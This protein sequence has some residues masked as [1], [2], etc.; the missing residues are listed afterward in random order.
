MINKFQIRKFDY[1][2]PEKGIYVAKHVEGSLVAK[3]KID[4]NSASI[5]DL[6]M[7]EGISDENAK[8]IEKTIL[9]L[10][11][12]L[13]KLGWYAKTESIQ[14][15]NNDLKTPEN[16]PL[17]YLTNHDCFLDLP[18]NSCIR[19]DIDLV[20]EINA[21]DEDL[22]LLYSLALIYG[23]DCISG[24]DIKH[25]LNHV[26][27][28]FENISFSEKNAL[29][30]L[31]S[32]SP[33]DPGNIFLRFLRDS[34]Y[35]PQKEKERLIAWIRGRSLIDLPYDDTDVVKAIK[36]ETD[37]AELRIKIFK[38]INDT[39]FQPI[40]TENADRIADMCLE[41]GM[42]IVAGRFS[43]ALYIDA[44]LMAN[45]RIIK[46]KHV[47]NDI[48]SL[49]RE[50]NSLTIDFNDDKIKK[51]PKDFSRIK[52]ELQAVLNLASEE[53][54]SYAQMQGTL[55]RFKKALRD[56]ETY[57]L[58]KLDEEC[59]LTSNIENGIFKLHNYRAFIR[60][61]VEQ[62]Y[63]EASKLEAKCLS[64]FGIEPV[65]LVFL[66]RIHPIDA[67]YLGTLNQLVDPFFGA[68]EEVHEL[69]RGCG[70]IMYTTANLQ[71]WLRKCDDWIEALPAYAEYEMISQKDDSSYRVSTFVWRSIMEEMYKQHAEDWAINIE[72]VMDLEHVALARE[73]LIKK[74]GLCEYVDKIANEEDIS[75]EQV[76][77]DIIK[78]E[79][80]INET[81]ELSA[82]I[83]AIYYDKCEQVARKV[84]SDGISR[85]EALVSL[86]ID[87][88]TINEVSSERVEYLKKLAIKRCRKI[89]NAHVLTTLGPGET[90][91]VE[92]WLDECMALFNVSRA[93]NLE[94][95][96]VKKL[97]SDYEDRIY[98]V[99]EKIVEELA[100]EG[101][102]YNLIESEA[103][104]DRKTAILRLI[105]SYPEVA[106]KVSEL[107]VLLD[108]EEKQSGS[109]ID[110]KNTNEPFI[111]TSFMRSEEFRKNNES[112]LVS[113][114]TDIKEEQINQLHSARQSVI[115]S[116]G[117]SDDVK[118]YLRDHSPKR[119]GYITARREVISN[120]GLLKELDN[121]RF[122]YE[123]RGPFKKYNL[124]YT[125]SRVDLGIDEVESVKN[126]PKWVGG[127]DRQAANAGKSLY[128]LY[129]LAGPTAM[130]M[131]KFAEFLKVGE[132]FFS[133]GGVFY[134]SLAAGANLDALGIGDFEF[135]RDQWNM[136]G[137]R[138]VLP[139]GETYGGFCVPKEFTL[140]YA[141][142]QSALD[143]NTSKEVLNAF[144]IPEES[145]TQLLD[146]LREILRMRSAFDSSIDWEIKATSFLME[147]G[148]LKY[149]PDGN[150]SYI[151]RLPRLAKTLE[152]KG[153]IADEDED[154][155]ITRYLM[156][157]WINK[158][159]HGLEEINRFGPFRKVF[160]I[161]NLVKEARRRNPNVLPDNKLIGVMSASYK[162]GGRKDGKEV[163]I[164]DV[165]FSAGSRKLEIYA[166]TAQNHL[167][168]HID[169]EG[170][171]LIKK[172]FKSIRP[173]ADIRI[174]GTC[175][176][177]DILNH[178]PGSGLEGIAESV[179]EK[180]LDAGLSQGVIEANCKIYG[181]DLEE[182][183][184][185]KEMQADKRRSLLDDIGG[186]IHLLVLINRGVFKKYEDAIQGI[187]FIDLG[188]P[189]PELLDLIDNL[190]KLIYLMRKGRPNSAL[191]FADGTSGARRRAFSFR[192]ASS[193]RKV[194]EL[195]ALDDNAVYGA[196]GLGSDT[197]ESWR[198]EMIRER[199]YASDLFNALVSKNF[200][201]AENIYNKIVSYIRTEGKAE[202]SAQEEMDAKR[203]KVDM[204]DYR[205]ISDRLGKIKAGL[206]LEQ[207]DFGTWL[208][209]GGMYCLNGKFNLEEIE[210]TKLQ[211][212]NAINEF[213]LKKGKLGIQ[214]VEPFPIDRFVKPKYEPIITTDLYKEIET[215][216]S[217]SLK[218]TEEKVGRLQKWE[219]RRKET[220][221]LRALAQRKKAFQECDVEAVSSL[222]NYEK[223]MS[224]IGD[225]KSEISQES[226]GKFIAYARAYIRGLF[227][228][229]SDKLDLVFSG[230]EISDEAYM[231]LAK[232]LG[233]LAVSANGDKDALEKIAIGMELLDIGFIIEKT[234]NIE[235][236]EEMS[237]AI[238]R[239]FDMTINNHIFDYIPY[240]YHKQHGAGFESLSREEKIDLATRH[241]RWLYTY[242]RHLLAEKSELKDKLESYKNA[243]IG[244]ADESIMAIGVS[245][246]DETEKFWFSYAR[247]RDAAV[248]RHEGYP[249]PEI[250]I[251]IDPNDIKC[252]ERTNIVIVYPHGNT[253]VPVALEQGA[254]LAK[255]E[256]I[257]LML[258]AFPYIEYD[259]EYGRNV[260]R[261]PDAF[262]YIGE[263]DYNNLLKKYRNT[264]D[265][266]IDKQGVLILAKFKEPIIAHGI[267][268][269][270]THPMRPEIG[271]IGTPIIQ[272]IIWEA[273]T[274]LKCSLPDMLKGSGVRT[275]DQINWY[276]YQSKGIDEKSAKAQIRKEL[277]RFAEDHEN[278][279]VKPEKESGGRM[280]RI[281]P[282]REGDKILEENINELADL[283]YNISKVD[284]VAI[285]DVLPSYVSRLYDRKFLK[286]MIDRFARI[287]VP[288][289]LDREHPTPLYSYFR[290][291]LV[292]GKDKY[293]IS[294][295]ITVISTRGIA[296]VG[297]GGILYEYT[298]DIINPKYRED[299]RRE[300]TKAAFNSMESQRK[301]IKEHWREILEIYLQIHP[302]FAGKVR[303]EVGE[304]LT[305]FSDADIPYEMGDY[306]PVFLVDENDNLVRIFDKETE[307][308]VPLFNDDG[309][310]TDVIIYDEKGEPI[311]RFD[312]NNN[313]IPIPMFDENGNRIPR[314]D[315]YGEPIS[316]LVV[317]KIEPNPGAGLWRPHND[318]LPEERKGE[319]V[320]IIFKYFGER[321]KIY[322]EKLTG[323][324]FFAST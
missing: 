295:H 25:A 128:S 227:S 225:G 149:A 298:D 58:E 122:R 33:I 38:A 189:D 88:N 148:I 203:L 94:S 28:F 232:E 305:G 59:N 50:I 240:H 175:T 307:E 42:R 242:I 285:Q 118:N 101:N 183:V 53:Y 176:A 228:E 29:L 302:E 165:R 61:K 271:T 288:V 31:L 134:L 195:F 5:L 108:Y 138:I 221:R 279:I 274:H 129:N 233:N 21:K 153:I 40:D 168:K 286:G 206:A 283:V 182:W 63:I 300:I 113:E 10:Q 20:D 187:D 191:V 222:H 57:C 90:E 106:R 198:N 154:D 209:I 304:D 220:L 32:Q 121:P 309:S 229:D 173:P 292:R 133:R 66:Q 123:S 269:H 186:R 213:A 136:R 115:K 319:G 184:D 249:L 199:Q 226:F 85:I 104:T 252:H 267:F 1:S 273:A 130:P 200:S 268:F 251:D 27:S 13:K 246:K 164:T 36:E 217:G 219:A 45:A 34:A 132:N 239:F 81:A 3:S 135:F 39:Y 96:T 92:N 265:V 230:G 119:L 143:P 316:T 64:I 41:K 55:S 127:M 318:Q 140:L 30:D 82:K 276:Q 141:I 116:L 272:P 260:L 117:L 155:M 207:M 243:W 257:N 75:R 261:I 211:F 289:F 291:V 124:L 313:S 16:I 4:L 218:A 159:A 77:I 223:A 160:M 241:H 166:E 114:H 266:K 324:K 238:A 299:L 310:P 161:Y 126:I 17:Y 69:I 107:A 322:K 74:R 112:Q 303:M 54:V 23:L 43:R 248:L 172:M 79:N 293:H 67:I 208:I 68:D 235:S 194:K 46:T 87:P 51:V 255:E 258:C 179:R 9:L 52:G 103:I 250:F 151:P 280:S 156:A 306:M 131:A 150:I 287:G 256:N 80:L 193:K 275:A 83:E 163:P 204:R 214:Y 201:D 254:K 264:S 197:I 174:V 142:I 210:K 7:I 91:N 72:E 37:L 190:P 321:A 245:V 169:P 263:E 196:L 178:V 73:M 231:D 109:T 262:M 95:N 111:V 202:E 26:I 158:K 84:E 212:E 15:S 120:K 24:V 6:N 181:G 146:G 290:Q 320:F 278:I 180:L 47:R 8:K 49:E 312:E 98:Y 137:D 152:S 215:G 14:R 294:H 216:I 71:G 19:L 282:V 22:A 284:N 167:F 44:M 35:K 192:Y 76:I 224:Y 105:D 237:I 188:I 110:P 170:R 18:D 78:R 315:R 277:R 253:T 48:S 147:K 2:I 236:P 93:Y 60:E 144:A 171:E 89:P 317:F 99:G 62:I 162:E 65:F 297:Q 259:E 323:E 97:V 11:E 157:N 86:N 270:F 247:L 314:Y 177:S 244:N 145:R 185:I 281:L 234:L 70:H 125:P 139:A 311:P 296:N 102:V 308:I 100:L 301:Y 56:F 205:L 12:G